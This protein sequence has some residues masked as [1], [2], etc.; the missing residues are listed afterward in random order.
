MYGFPYQ[1]DVQD[2]NGSIS[3]QFEY[4]RTLICRMVLI[5]RIIVVTVI[6]FVSVVVIGIL[7]IFTRKAGRCLIIIRTIL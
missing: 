1:P 7:V 2:A 3:T 4:Q 5:R 6:D